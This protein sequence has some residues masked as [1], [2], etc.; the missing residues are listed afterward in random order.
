[1]SLKLIT[2]PTASV[3]TLAE[4]KVH[5]REDLVDAGNDALI[6]AI[7]SAATQDAEHLMGR[8][9]LP[10]TWQLTL[11]AFPAVIDLPRPTVT[12]VASVAYVHATTG[13]LTTLD[14]GQYQTCLGSDIAAA[15]VPA[16]G[17]DWP[18]VRSQPESVQVTYTSGWAT[19]A[20]VPELVKA[21][22]KLRMG[23]LYETRQSWTMGQR[24][25]IQ[26][27]PFID[28]LLD[29]HRVWAC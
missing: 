23:A 11:D 25:A 24:E 7:I 5:L 17:C 20:D 2:P 1:M 27:N 12:T 14:P 8:A 22:I 16:Y 9:I 18:D 28:F 29:R 3:L 19:P 10:Q 26:A 13:T 15:I 6:T 21:W 4:A